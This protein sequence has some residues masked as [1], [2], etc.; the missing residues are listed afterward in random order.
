MCLVSLQ[1]GRLPLERV[2]DDGQGQLVHGQR[3]GGG[4]TVTGSSHLRRD[5]SESQGQE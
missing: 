1:G 2:V 3:V 4:G 5:M